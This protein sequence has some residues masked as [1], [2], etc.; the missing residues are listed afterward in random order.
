[1]AVKQDRRAVRL[2]SAHALSANRLL[3][4]LDASE[5]DGLFGSAR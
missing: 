1:M 3:K 5:V 4:N 2:E